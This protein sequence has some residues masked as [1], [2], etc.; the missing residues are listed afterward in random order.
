MIKAVIFDIDNTLYSYDA[1]HAAAWEVL[2][3]YAREHL[4]MDREEFTRCHKEAMEIVKERL[5]ADCAAL[6]D[7]CLRYQILLEKHTLP[8]HH[9]LTMSERYWDTLIRAAVPTPGIMECLPN[10]KEAGYILGIGTDMTLEYQLKKLIGLQMLPYF[11]FVV[12]SEEVNTE[13]PGEKLFLTC[14]RKAGVTPGECLFVGDNLRK[15]IQGSRNAGMKALW[16]AS[17]PEL[18]AR[19]P[20]IDSITHYSQLLSRLRG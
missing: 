15:D 16:F 2:C 11:D 10:L 4:G 14:A 6:H 7:R 17:S 1:A 18:A 8:L 5:G 13:K 20:E 9:A 19:H 12:T 3:G